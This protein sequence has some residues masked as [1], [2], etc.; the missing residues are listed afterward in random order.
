M[1]AIKIPLAAAEPLFADSR[2]KPENKAMNTTA[3]LPGG[4]QSAVTKATDLHTASPDATPWAPSFEE[5]SDRYDGFE[6][7]IEAFEAGSTTRCYCRD[8]QVR[9][10]SYNH[11]PDPDAMAKHPIRTYS[12]GQYGALPVVLIN[13]EAWCQLKAAGKIA[14]VPTRDIT[15]CLSDCEAH[16]RGTPGYLKPDGICHLGVI[17]IP[18]DGIRLEALARTFME[19]RGGRYLTERLIGEVLPDVYS[20]K[21]ALAVD[22]GTGTEPGAA[23]IEFRVM[24]YYESFV[25]EFRATV[26]GTQVW[27]NITDLDRYVR[28]GEK[29]IVRLAGGPRVVSIPNKDVIDADDGSGEHRYVLFEAF[30]KILRSLWYG[31]H[32]ADD[33]ERWVSN[34]LL[35]HETQ[36][37]SGRFVHAASLHKMLGRHMDLEMWVGD[38]DLKRP[39]LEC[40][41]DLYH[42]SNPRDLKFP[43][44]VAR[45]LA[46]REDG[47]FGQLVGRL[48]R[49]GG[50]L[51]GGPPGESGDAA[52]ARFSGLVPDSAG[53]VDARLAHE[54]MNRRVPFDDWVE[55]LKKSHGWELDSELCHDG[56]ITRWE[57]ENR[58]LWKD[59][60]DSLH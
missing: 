49:D 39:R 56:P 58:D 33:L 37:K 50:W 17:G 3:K 28:L 10:D 20:G 43:L 24:R 34:D 21:P 25:G 45:D 29:V 13:G 52:L 5:E 59:R 14:G 6:F 42:N 35:S 27:F 1:R 16:I 31:G 32:L 44:T 36:L 22:S 60:L 57:A 53:R 48:L 19:T 26:I 18:G 40:Y 2:R 55:T 46:F 12:F 9:R 11:G 4:N 38:M 47:Y 41:I 30:K 15:G 8:D 7:E 23:P 54:F 51:H